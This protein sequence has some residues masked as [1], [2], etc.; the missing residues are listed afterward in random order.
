MSLAYGSNNKTVQRPS[1]LLY[2][3]IIKKHKSSMIVLKFVIDEHLYTV[4]ENLIKSYHVKVFTE[5]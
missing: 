4:I 3:V 1:K 2:D 5:E